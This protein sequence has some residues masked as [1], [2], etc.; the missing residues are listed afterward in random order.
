MKLMPLAPITIVALQVDADALNPSPYD[1]YRVYGRARA[2]LSLA[3]GRNPTRAELDAYML[4][5]GSRLFSKTYNAAHALVDK[6]Q[7]RQ[8]FTQAAYNNLRLIYQLTQTLW[9]TKEPIYP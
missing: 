4:Q 6:P 7:P 2:A 1:C 5:W 3:L 8:T 9:P